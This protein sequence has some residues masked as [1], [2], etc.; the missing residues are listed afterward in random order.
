MSDTNER[1]ELMQKFIGQ[2]FPESPS[3]YMRW[4]NPVVR[5]AE[6]G[7][8]T[9][10]YVIRKEMTNPMA[11]LH[12]GITAGIMD[13][14]IGATVFTMGFSNPYTTINNN[15]DYFAPAR[16]GDIIEARTSVIKRGQQIINLQCELW[17]PS[18]NRLLAKGYSN[19]IR[20]E[21]R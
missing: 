20:L 2:E 11:V 5:G 9:F 18:K 13:D 1:L 14:I 21:A 19:M 3:P 8:L 4:L 15:I 12:G 17:L 16:E 10:E 6:Y 7:S